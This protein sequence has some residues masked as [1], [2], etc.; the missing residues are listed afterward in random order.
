VG[1]S[2]I[3]IE[4]SAGTTI[5]RIKRPEVLNALDI[6]TL[7]E[8]KGAF[9]ALDEEPGVKCLILTGAGSKS[10]VAGAD[11]NELKA[12]DGSEGQ[13]FSEEGQDVFSRLEAFSKPVIAA[14]NGYCLGGGC[15]LALASHI[16]VASESAVFGLPEVKLGLIPGYG[17]TQRLARLVGTAHATQLILTGESIS[18]DMAL[19]IGLV[20]KVTSKEELI[21]TCLNIAKSIERNGPVAVKLALE[22]IRI[23]V[24][25]P[26]DEGLELE[27][28]QFGL[29]CAS[30]DSDEGIR[31]FLDKRKANFKGN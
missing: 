27:A 2:N 4:S 14:V 25:L 30:E 31:A 28:R 20:N 6:Q 13:A 3:E 18:A 11:I 19:R 26:L 8:L 21:P 29:A 16:R 9:S 1:F 5:L 7:L 24:D 12:L 22:A 23:G 10:F 15:E 17:G